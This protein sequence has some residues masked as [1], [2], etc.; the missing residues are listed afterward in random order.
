M[1]LMPTE[2]INVISF[3]DSGFVVDTAQIICTA[4]KDENVLV[5]IKTSWSLG[6]L[7]DALVLSR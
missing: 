4:Y 6:N 7:S 3:Q 2:V 1:P 5:R